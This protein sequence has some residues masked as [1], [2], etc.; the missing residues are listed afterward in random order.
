MAATFLSGFRVEKSLNWKALVYAPTVGPSRDQFGELI[1][2]TSKNC[3]YNVQ[4]GLVI[5]DL[6]KDRDDGTHNTLQLWPR[7]GP[8]DSDGKL[9]S[10]GHSDGDGMHPGHLLDALDLANSSAL[11]VK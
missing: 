1:A 4:P 5:I 9:L 11:G 7:R 8:S 6:F 3:D 10:N 2:I